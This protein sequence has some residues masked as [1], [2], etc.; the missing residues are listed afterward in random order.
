MVKE[1]LKK[2]VTILL[3]FT[4]CRKVSRDFSHFTITKEELKKIYF[5]LN[6]KALKVLPDLSTLWNSSYHMLRRRACI[7]DCL[8][9]YSSNSKIEQFDDDEWV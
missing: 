1:A 2:V 8:S 9:L 5:R 3:L 7:K 4:K 6:E